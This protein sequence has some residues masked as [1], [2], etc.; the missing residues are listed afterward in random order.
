MISYFLIGVSILVTLY[1]WQNKTLLMYGMNGDFLK[2][3]DYVSFWKQVLAFQFIHGD[4]LHIVMNSYF[5][6][7]AGPIIEEILGSA[8]YGVFFITSTLFSV[9]MLFFFASRQNTIGISGF[10]MSIL[11]Y[12]W[13]LLYSSGS[14]GTEEIG[15]LLIIN[16]VIGFLPGISLVGHVAG[17]I[18]GILFWI[19]TRN[20]I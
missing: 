13:I 16:I 18:W 15:R 1:V 4:V 2:K 11:S 20:F 3:G 19:I 8:R 12:L 10:C 6:Y 14:S 9:A 5:L 17:A 7:S